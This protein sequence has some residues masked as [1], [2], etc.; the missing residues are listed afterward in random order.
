[1]KRIA[2]MTV[3]ALALA[4]PGCMS[5]RAHRHSHPT[6]PHPGHRS[7]ACYGTPTLGRELMDLKDA[8]TRRAISKEEH[9]QYKVTLKNLPCRRHHK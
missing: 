7:S 2:L 5:F 9:E 3:L 1:M 4:L 6:L 8:R